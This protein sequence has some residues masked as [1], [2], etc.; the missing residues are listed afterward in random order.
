MTKPYKIRVELE[1]LGM[2]L[3]ALTQEGLDMFHFGVCHKLMRLFRF[4]L[5]LAW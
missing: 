1:G 5:I 3:E 4:T 2:T